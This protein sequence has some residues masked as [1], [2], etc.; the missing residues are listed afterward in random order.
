MQWGDLV[1]ITVVIMIEPPGGAQ[2]TIAPDFPSHEI[3]SMFP[4]GIFC[5]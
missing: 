3:R 2:Q 5:L 4:I 1:V